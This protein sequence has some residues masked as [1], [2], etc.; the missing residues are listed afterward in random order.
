MGAASGQ[1]GGSKLIKPATAL[2]LVAVPL[3]DMGDYEREEVGRAQGGVVGV[4]VV[5]DVFG[6]LSR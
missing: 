2:Y 6:P 1:V 5:A 3:F 4:L